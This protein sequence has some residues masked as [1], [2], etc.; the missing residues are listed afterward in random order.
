MVLPAE[1]SPQERYVFKPSF[2]SSHHWALS[3]LQGCLSGKRVL[4]IGA[5]G[6]NIGRMI[7]PQAPAELV[8]VEIDTRAHPL[9]SQI[10]TE[11]HTSIEPLSGRQFD[12]ILLLDLLE[13]LADPFEF[14]QRL[15]PLLAPGACL[16]ISVPNIAHWSVR[17]PL[18]F[19][20]RFEYRS[21]GILDATHLFF[22]TAK[23][24]REL[25]ASIPGAT[26]ESSSVS[27]EPIELLLPKWACENA[28]FSAASRIRKWVAQLLPGLMAY[29]LLAVVR[30]PQKALK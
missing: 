30:L 11:V 15:R 9:L 6:G 21:R 13:H 28:L 20:G 4:D 19:L 16:V 14:V 3:Q 27:I 8:A 25:C 18:F 22:F 10:Y 1:A 29:Q 12:C 26:I 24:L 2:G 5:G 23:R 7:H 17:F